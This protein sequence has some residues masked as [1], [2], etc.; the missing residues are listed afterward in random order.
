MTIVFETPGL[1]D[2]RAFTIGGLTAKPASHN[3][4]GRFGTGLKYAIAVL[5]RMGADPVVWIGKDRYQFTKKSID[6]RGKSV[7]IIQMVLQKWSWRKPRTYEM[8][9]TTEYGRDWQP[10]MVFRELEANTRDENGRTIH[11]QTTASYIDGETGK[12]LILVAH[13]DFE[14]AYE[15]RDTVFLPP[16]LVALQEDS[17]LQQF[18]G[19]SKYLYWRGMRVLELGK[20]S[21]YTWNILRDMDLTE[22]RTLR[23]EFLARTYLAEWVARLKDEDTI[24]EFLTVSEK[25]WESAMDFTWASS[26]SSQFRMVARAR[27]EGMLRSAA[28]WADTHEPQALPENELKTPWKIKQEY[29]VDCDDRRVFQR[30]D[31]IPDAEWYNL[32]CKT[33][34]IINKS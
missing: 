17:Q 33:V 9:F 1:I 23:H 27:P 22:D 29:V 15:Q 6:F 34:E 32:A 2:P 20:P 19:E 18:P 31:S 4:I 10:W 21:R 11:L 3:P 30:P 16:D 8:P 25:W 13:S 28:S 26:I 7:D 14:A 12:T 24:R 5:V